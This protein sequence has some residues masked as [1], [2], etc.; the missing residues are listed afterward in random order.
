MKTLD[1]LLRNLEAKALRLGYHILHTESCVKFFKDGIEYHTL[2][3]HSTNN[4]FISEKE[5]IE[6]MSKIK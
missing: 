6:H 1:E 5:Y 2:W 4:D 3:K